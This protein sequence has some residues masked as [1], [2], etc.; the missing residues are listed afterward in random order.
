MAA[1]KDL[2]RKTVLEALVVDNHD[3]LGGA[4]QE[5]RRQAMPHAVGNLGEM[6]DEHDRI[7]RPPPA[8]QSP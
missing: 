5:R 6:L 4:A 8:S 1:E 3:G 2:S 7:S